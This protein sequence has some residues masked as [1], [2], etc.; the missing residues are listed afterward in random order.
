MKEIYV[1][2]EWQDQNYDKFVLSNS[3]TINATID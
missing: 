3:I 2:L 1:K